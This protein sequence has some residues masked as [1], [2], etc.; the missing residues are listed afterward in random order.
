MV[1]SA[2]R[3]ALVDFAT[4]FVIEPIVMLQPLPKWK[5]DVNAM[6]QPFQPQV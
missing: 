2:E 6:F 3:N 5:I 1:L 4:T